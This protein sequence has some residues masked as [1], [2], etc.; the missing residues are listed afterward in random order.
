MMDCQLILPW[1][2]PNLD[3]VTITILRFVTAAL[4]MKTTLVNYSDKDRPLSEP[5]W[6]RTG[7]VAEWL[8]STFGGL[9]WAVGDAASDS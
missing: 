8:R 3:N 6:V 7:S 1:S 9:L 5:K 4:S 2:S